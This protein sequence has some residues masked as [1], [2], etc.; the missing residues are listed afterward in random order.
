MI[1]LALDQASRVSG[2]SIFKDKELIASGTIPLADDHLGQ[3]LVYLRQIVIDLVNKY[4]VDTILLEDIQ[5]QQNAETH[6]ILGEVL[7]SLEELATELV[8]TNYE[9]IPS[10]RWKSGLSIKGKQRAEQKRNAQKYVQENYGK[11]VTQDESD[12]ICIGAYYVN[13]DV[14][15]NWED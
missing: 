7:G 5:L 11:K 2:Y 13:R 3:R 4:N 10:V 6:K 12:A 8:G 14:G 9:V 15:L 1:V